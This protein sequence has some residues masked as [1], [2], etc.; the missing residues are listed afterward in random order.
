MATKLKTTA[1]RILYIL[2]SIILFSDCIGQTPTNFIPADDPNIQY[3]GRIDFSNPL[4]PTYSYP[5]VTISAKFNGTAISG[6]FQDYGTGGA[7][8]TNYYNVFIDNV[9]IKAL[10]IMSSTTTYS[11]ATD[12][13]NTTHTISLTKRTE[14]SVGK[15]AF[16]GFYIEGN[17]LLTP[18][19][20]PINKIEFIGDSWTCGYG[21]ELA[22]TGGQYVGFN[23]VNEDNYS[24]WGAI[25]SRRLNAQYHCTAYSGRG[26]YRNNSG[27]TSG[28]I[29]QVYPRIFPDDANSVWNYNNYIPDVCVIHL[30]T[31][32]FFPEQYMSF[33]WIPY[34]QG[35]KEA[36]PEHSANGSGYSN[37][38]LEH[39]M[40]LEKGDIELP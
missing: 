20:M 8:T 18:D 39:V 4:A 27:S 23:S 11:L 9:F 2:T 16:K 26:M 19:A 3:M 24:A 14:S 1:K 7:Q 28:V 37:G 22:G 10:K 5:G 33:G 40:I 21:N 30:G 25:T 36:Y 35:D 38:D 12:L 29:P 13:S 32:D 34:N 31:N 15:S 17:S 6:D